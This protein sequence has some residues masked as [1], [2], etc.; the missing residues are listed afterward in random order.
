MGYKTIVGLSLCLTILCA[1]GC[2]ESASPPHH[3]VHG[4]RLVHGFQFGGIY[5]GEWITTKTVDGVLVR[6]VRHDGF[7]IGALFIGRT[8]LLYPK[9][10]SAGTSAPDTPG[11][12]QVNP[13]PDNQAQ[14]V[15]TR[16]ASQPEKGTPP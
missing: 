3:V 14:L 11:Q 10:A 6:E 15:A 5:S 9:P 12:A 16:P 13:L 8:K 4:W 2:S 1:A 7:D